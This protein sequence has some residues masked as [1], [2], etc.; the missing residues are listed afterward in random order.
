MTEQVAA[1]VARY[2]KLGKYEKG[3][4]LIVCRTDCFDNLFCIVNGVRHAKLG[5][6]RRRFDKTV[7]HIKFLSKI[8]FLADIL[9]FYLY[10]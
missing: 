8:D 10:F 1:G 7:F 5:G 9:S 3:Y 2:A 6:D 4:T